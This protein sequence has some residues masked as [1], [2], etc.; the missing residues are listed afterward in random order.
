M[1]NYFPSDWINSGLSA[2]GLILVVEGQISPN[3][4]SGLV[5]FWYAFRYTSSYLTAPQPFQKVYLVGLEK[6]VYLGGRLL[7]GGYQ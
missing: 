2:Q 3:P 1:K 5:P 7:V 6:L 4:L